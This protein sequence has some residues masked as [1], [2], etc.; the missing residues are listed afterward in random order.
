MP[1]PALALNASQ[2]TPEEAEEY[3]L[4]TL[5][6]NYVLYAT[7]TLLVYELL[8]TFDEEVDRVWSLKWRLPKV[9]FIINRY[10][11]RALLMLQFIAGDYPGTSAEF[12][13]IYAVWQVIPARLAILVAQAVMVIRLW[14]IYN[15]SKPMLHVLLALYISEVA[16]VVTCSALASIETQGASQPSP[17]GCGLEPRSP[18][19]KNYASGTWIAPV[20]FEFIILV[21]TLVKIIPPPS[22]P[23]L[24]RANVFKGLSIAA[25]NSRNPTLDI[26][27][28]DSIIYF[29]FVFTFTLT[30]A[31]LY[32]LSFAAFYRAILLGY[33]FIRH[34]A[35]SHGLSTDRR[36]PFHVSPSPA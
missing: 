6:Q 3:V 11:A 31:V 1:G 21:L 33:G 10:I 2:Y 13:A 14:A 4:I 26:L 16:A 8:T 7:T 36:P 30:N 24:G 19:L 18:M 17:L 5:T 29:A 34:A 12:C 23:F 25:R 9:L 22:F 28:R 35:V 15:N 32:E 20:C 27:A